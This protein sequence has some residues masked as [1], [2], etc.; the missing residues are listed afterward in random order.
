MGKF[1]VHRA[2]R[3]LF[4][5]LVS[6]FITLTALTELGDPFKVIGARMQDPTTRAN[7][8]EA[9]GL[10]QPL[11]VR[12]VH[13][14]ANLATG[15]L[16]ID[17]ERR[18]PVIDILAEMAPNSLLLAVV[19]LAIQAVVGITLGIIAARLRHSFTDLVIITSAIVVTVIPLFVLAVWVRNIFSGTSV[20]GWVA[21][22]QLPRSMGI[23]TSWLQEL[24][25]PAIT[26]GFGALSLTV[27]LT[28]GSMLEVLDADYVRT[29]RLAIT[30]YSVALFVVVLMLA[31]ILT[32]W[33]DPRIRTTD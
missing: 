31:D 28:R 29:A 14:V 17:Y 30:V 13:F 7:L 6:S 27:V 12:Y 4:V 3:M 8:N 16:G 23:E 18:R 20:F 9:F 24:L 26:L 25:L 32:A 11:L 19:A 10:D 5:L 2:S 15:D 1:L 21:F 22:P 33:L